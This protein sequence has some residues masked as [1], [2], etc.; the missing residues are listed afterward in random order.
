MPVQTVEEFDAY[1][2]NESEWYVIVQ[3]TLDDGRW[4]RR[5]YKTPHIPAPLID[6][7]ELDENL[8]P[9]MIPDPNWSSWYDP[10]AAIAQAQTDILEYFKTLD[11]QDQ[12]DAGSDSASGEADQNEVRREYVKRSF[13]EPVSYRALAMMDNFMPNLIALGLTVAQYATLLETTEENVT[14][15]WQRWQYLDENR[16]AVE[17]Y[18]TIQQGDDF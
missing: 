8:D 9:I 7:G 12:V 14:R 15:L 16:T 4:K 5:K 18:R 11:A 6:S 2:L 3:A 13:Q 10:S 17:A 1:R